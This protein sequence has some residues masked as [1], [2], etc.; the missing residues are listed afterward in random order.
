MQ[1]TK[2]RE[3]IILNQV[4]NS[5]FNRISKTGSK[6]AGAIKRSKQRNELR[7]MLSVGGRRNVFEAVKKEPILLERLV[8]V[9]SNRL[10][11]PK[12]RIYA[13]EVIMRLSAEGVDIS[14]VRRTIENLELKRLIPLAA[15]KYINAT[16]AKEIIEL[17]PFS[18]EF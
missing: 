7:D 11:S 5:I 13:A 2:F 12:V 8:E 14:R 1:T 9:I 3:Y 10:E 15:I 6:I 16:L 18:D 4:L 17:P